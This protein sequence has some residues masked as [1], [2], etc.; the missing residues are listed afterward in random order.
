MLLRSWCGL[1]MLFVSQW[2]VSPAIAGDVLPI[3]I[4]KADGSKVNFTAELA[5]TPKELATGLMNRDSLD[6]D[7]GMLFDFGSERPV[8]MWMKNTLIPLDMLF[9]DKKGKIVY[10]AEN[11]EPLSL[12][13]IEAG[14]PV[15]YVLEIGGGESKANGITA[16]D[17]LRLVP[18]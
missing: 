3:A 4:V 9:I 1:L 7:K 17:K 10:I 11:T 8:K 15:R 5:S 16:G 6:A 18:R 2:L 13:F 14:V 12:D